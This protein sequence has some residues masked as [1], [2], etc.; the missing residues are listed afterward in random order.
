MPKN[1]FETF[2]WLIF[3]VNEKLE[4]LKNEKRIIAMHRKGI[5]FINIFADI[6]CQLP[7]LSLEIL[8]R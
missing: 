7:K 2:L 3:L 8:H 6:S 1:Y 5:V 4:M